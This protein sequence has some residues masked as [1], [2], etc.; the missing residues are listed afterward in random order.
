MARRKKVY[1]AMSGGVDSSVAAG[2]LLRCGY[3]VTGVTFSFGRAIL[4]RQGL[5]DRVSP[6]GAEA[7][8]AADILGI[9]HRIVPAAAVFR[10]QVVDPFCAQY[11][12]G[13]T[14]NPC[15]FCNEHIK[16]GLL[17]RWA[18]EEGAQALATGHYA[19]IVSERRAKARFFVLRKAQDLRKDQSYFLYRLQQR[20]L[21]SVFFP[22]GELTKDAV[23]R[24]AREWGL[25]AAEKA[26]S[27]E[28]CFLPQNDY[29]SF[30]R[31]YAARR[32]RRGPIRELSGRVVGEHGGIGLYT[33]G[34][35][36]GL[37]VA[38]GY[39]AYVV[40]IDT[41]EN[42]IYVG[43]RQQACSR[44]FEV[45]QLSFIAG[46]LQKK[47]ALHV[48]IRYNHCESLADIEP[49]GAALAV[50]FRRPQF[51]VTPGQ[52]AVIYD[53]DRVVGGGIIL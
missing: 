5:L 52:S 22:L 35:R 1:V 18:Q 36:G 30:L 19:R 6:A 37:G 15:V 51:A 44:S 7:R 2:L 16:F 25:P 4:R 12:R 45:G 53:R 27:Q 11:L 8:R 10:K 50:R 20:Q 47:V 34:Q 29:R 3:E 14:P 38:L 26:Q 32:L 40:R 21:R 33:V 43:S 42:T 23:Y 13:R 39:P 31:G 9:R 24:L 49:Q 17:L 28:I 48:R 41:G 46:P